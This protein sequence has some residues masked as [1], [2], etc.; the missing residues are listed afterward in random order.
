MIG[1]KVHFVATSIDSKSESF[2]L[3]EPRLHRA[4]ASLTTWNIY[5]MEK[6]FA[7]ESSRY[8]SIRFPADPELILRC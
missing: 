1:L 8:T 3:H 4:T 6:S 5:F 2:F 7:R